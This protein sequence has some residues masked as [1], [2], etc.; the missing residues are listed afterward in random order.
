MVTARSAAMAFNRLVDRD[1]DQDNPRTARRHIPAGLLSVRGVAL[2]TRCNERGLFLASDA[3]VPAEPLAAVPLGSGAAVPAGLLVREAV[4]IL[5]PLLAQRAALMLSP[6][7]AWIAIR[8]TVEWPRRSAG[9]GDL[10]LGRRA[11]TSSTPRRT[12]SS[13][14]SESCTASRPGTASRERCGWRP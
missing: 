10:L 4:D 12:P 13:T 2:F 5:V 8:G 1:I 7:A 11:S 9:G 6:I 3:A 14:A